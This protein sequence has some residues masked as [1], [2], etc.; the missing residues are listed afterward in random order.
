MPLGRLHRSL[1][2]RVVTR[3]FWYLGA[4]LGDYFGV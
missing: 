4:E 3:F 2:L 1:A